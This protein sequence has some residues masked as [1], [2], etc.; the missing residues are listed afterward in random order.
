MW[1]FIFDEIVRK[2]IE[3]GLVTGK[4]LLIDSTHIRAN[5]RNDLREIIEVPD[6]PSEYMQK[7][8]REA[9]ETRLLKEPNI[10]RQILI[11]I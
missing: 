8:D 11:I 2:C 7:L 9:Y 10:Y 6:M 4:L 5:A 1:I 3:A